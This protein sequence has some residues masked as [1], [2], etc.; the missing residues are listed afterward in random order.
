M[1]NLEKQHKVNQ[2]IFEILNLLNKNIDDI[3]RYHD[4][5]LID[6]ASSADDSILELKQMID[7]SPVTNNPNK[8]KLE[9]R[10][11]NFLFE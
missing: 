1:D 4:Y 2:K 10:K 8:V 7:D 5:L 3:D 9:P 11:H 6:S